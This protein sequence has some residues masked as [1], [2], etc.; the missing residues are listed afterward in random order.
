MGQSAQGTLY[1]HCLDW[2]STFCPP[3]LAFSLRSCVSTSSG[4]IHSS[5]LYW[6]RLIHPHLRT[7]LYRSISSPSSAL[8]C[9]ASPRWP[10]AA[11]RCLLA[12]R[13][14]A[15]WSSTGM[16]T[17]AR[18]FQQAYLGRIPAFSIP[19]CSEYTVSGCGPS[20][21]ASGACPKTCPWLHHLQSMDSALAGAL[22][23]D[24]PGLHQR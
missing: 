10:L 1:H 16:G 13:C 7:V 24:R 19:K 4:R 22:H 12:R 9:L 2:R 20:H 18:Y 5:T 23:Y 15:V 14:I 3:A 8:G 6:R 17:T 21:H 11:Q